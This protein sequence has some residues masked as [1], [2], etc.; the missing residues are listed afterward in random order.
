LP[1][2]VGQLLGAAVTTAVRMVRSR[3]SMVVSPV[4]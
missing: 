2:Y 4:A 3:S 1:S